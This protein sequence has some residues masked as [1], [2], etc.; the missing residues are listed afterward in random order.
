MPSTKRNRTSLIPNE[1]LSSTKRNRTSLIPIEHLSMGII[2][3]ENNIKT[4]LN[5]LLKMIMFYK[6][7]LSII[8]T[9]TPQNKRNIFKMTILNI[10]LQKLNWFLIIF[11]PM[12][13]GCIKQI[14]EE[15]NKQQ[16]L[17]QILK[18]ID[19]INPK[20]ILKDF[21]NIINY[22]MTI[23]YKTYYDS[24]DINTKY[25][26]FANFLTRWLE[27]YKSNE[28]SKKIKK[29]Q[30][31]TLILISNHKNKN[32]IIIDTNYY[33]KL[34]DPYYDPS[35]PILSKMSKITG[36]RHNKSNSLDMKYIKD[37]CKANQIKLSI[38][39]NDERIIYTKKELI[40][41]LKRKN[42]I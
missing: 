40:T 37:L 1:H 38:T 33:N 3:S 36:G 9:N 15:K 34:Y 30:N 26:E 23:F 8:S 25:F 7:K 16:P 19:C 5:N 24:V 14:E 21:V 41:K 42:I 28:D 35:L 13:N 6:K 2:N 11:K 32:N 39:K 27:I 29:L 10:V 22:Y 4:F 17:Q 18:A 31:D 12:I 20:E